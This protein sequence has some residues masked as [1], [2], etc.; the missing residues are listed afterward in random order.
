[1]NSRLH[2][3]VV[4]LALGASLARAESTPARAASSRPVSPILVAL[5]F[6]HDGM[7]SDREISAAPVTLRAL[8]ANDDGLITPNELRAV[9]AEGRVIRSRHGATAFNVVLTLD[10]NHDGDIQ[11]LEIANAVSS[12]KRLDLNGDGMLSP[13]EL[14]AGARPARRIVT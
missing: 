10:A 2:F 11:T 7:L 9:D 1:M 8:D 12:L 3:V 6:D 5:D 14:A 13:D 4:L